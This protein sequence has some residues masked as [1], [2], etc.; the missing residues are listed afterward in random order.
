[1]T[2]SGLSR[3]AMAEDHKRLT[4]ITKTLPLLPMG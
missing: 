3:D 1:M 2:R 4:Y